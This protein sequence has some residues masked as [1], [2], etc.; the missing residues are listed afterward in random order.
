MI[1]L[2]N[3][4]YLATQKRKDAEVLFASGRYNGAVYLMSYALE[5]M[6]KRRIAHTL[7]FASGFPDKTTARKQQA[8]VRAQAPEGARTR[9]ARRG[10][11]ANIQ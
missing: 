2:R 1:S 11:K 9:P 8:R 5:L 4:T 10:K 3:L 6:L 7:S